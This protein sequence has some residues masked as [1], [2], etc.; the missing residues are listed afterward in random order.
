MKEKKLTVSGMMSN[1]REVVPMIRM[2]GK[3]LKEI[4][5]DVGSKYR[6]EYKKGKLILEV[7]KEED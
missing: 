6:V 7:I 4:G 2:Q 3:R 5:F 1:N